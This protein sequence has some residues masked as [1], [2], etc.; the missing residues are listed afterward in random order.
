MFPGF[1]THDWEEAVFDLLNKWCILYIKLIHSSS[2]VLSITY[3][4]KHAE[5]F[6]VGIKTF[7]VASF[8]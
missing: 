7:K 3:K 8:C 5:Y 6:S 2:L 4:Y 1:Q